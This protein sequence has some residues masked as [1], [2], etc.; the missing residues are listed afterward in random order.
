MMLS[1]KLLLI[2][3]FVLAKLVINV[4][5]LV[6]ITFLKN[7]MDVSAGWQNNFLLRILSHLGMEIFSR[8]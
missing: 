8:Y 2:F 3:S 5:W 4:H 1:V 7:F 6:N